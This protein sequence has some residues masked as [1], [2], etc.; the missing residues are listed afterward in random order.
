MRELLLTLLLAACAVV[1]AEAQSRD[2]LVVRYTIY[3]DWNSIEA[4]GE[5][6]QKLHEVGKWLKDNST[7]KV[8][9]TGWADPLH[10]EEGSIRVA[11][12]RANAA[13]QWL[14][15]RYDISPERIALGK[16][17][18]DL[19]AKSND[20]ARRVDIAEMIQIEITSQNEPEE[21]VVQLTVVEQTKSETKQE[22]AIEN[23]TVIIA[24]VVEQP[25]KEIA[26][27]P[28]E[29][30]TDTPQSTTKSY[31]IGAGAGANLVISSFKGV[32][33]GTQIFGG[34]EFSRLISAELSLDYS[35]ANMTAFE[36]C[37]NLYYANGK[38][39]YAP[40]AGV[41]CYKYADIKS[42]VNIFQ[43]G[44]KVNFDILSIFKSN[45]PWGVLLSP[46]VGM[47]YS[48]ADIKSAGAKIGSGDATHFSAGVDVAGA[49]RLNDKWGLRL[50]VGA[51]YLSGKGID[52]MPQSEQKPNYILS[53]QLSVTYKF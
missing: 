19:S 12:R 14:Q 47:A 2:S 20:K 4:Q 51:D 13:S 29:V 3:Y 21:E 38:R 50:T 32:G 52:A 8:T 48:M 22:K 1:S 5:Q 27:A 9:L 23:E 6:K 30:I 40:I 26:E 46:K 11:H 39:Y 37:E 7:T 53:S 24:E 44:A 10:N 45:T 49:Y 31:Y 17:G 36:G 34:V 16:G 28:Q 25:Q 42:A 33:F 43:L 18:I 15:V 35:R 41:K